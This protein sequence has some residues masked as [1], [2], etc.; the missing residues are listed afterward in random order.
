[1]EGCGK[2]DMVFRVDLAPGEKPISPRQAARRWERHIKGKLGINV[3]WY[4]LKHL[5]ATNVTEKLNNIEAMKLTG[6]KSTKMIDETYDVRKKLRKDDALK[7][8]DDKFGH[9]YLHAI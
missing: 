2:K 8:L 4:E 6:H 3:G 1:M 7:S 5:K 9:S